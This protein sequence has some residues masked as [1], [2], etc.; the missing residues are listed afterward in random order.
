MKTKNII[1]KELPKYINFVTYNSDN[2]DIIPSEY[3]IA[4]LL[5]KRVTLN[6]F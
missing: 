4:K 6:D 2:K 3:I 1:L 5:Y